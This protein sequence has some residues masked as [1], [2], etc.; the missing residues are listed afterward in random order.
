MDG[1]V[2]GAHAWQ[3]TG[4]ASCTTCPLTVSPHQSF[5]LFEVLSGFLVIHEHVRNVVTP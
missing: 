2:D 4:Q 1:I 3:A 5:L